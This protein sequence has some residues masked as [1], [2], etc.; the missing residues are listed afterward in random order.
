MTPSGGTVSLLFTDLVGSTALM[1]QIG[2]EPAEDLRRAH[3]RLLRQA[4]AAN[5]GHEAKNLGD[6]LMVVF[7]SATSAVACAVAIQRAVRRHNQDQPHPM[8]VRVGIN[9]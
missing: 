6:G 2:D 4:V 5:Q 9:V 7:D 3:Y 1:N 8:E